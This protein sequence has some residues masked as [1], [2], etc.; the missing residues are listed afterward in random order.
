MSIAPALEKQIMAHLALMTGC[1]MTF[2]GCGFISTVSTPI[3]IHS[4]GQTLLIRWSPIKPRL[5]SC[6]G[7]DPFL[8]TCRFN[9]RILSPSGLMPSQVSAGSVVSIASRDSQERQARPSKLRRPA[10]NGRPS[11]I[12][13]FKMPSILLARGTPTRAGIRRDTLSTVE[14]SSSSDILCRSYP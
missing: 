2:H 7:P 13:Y 14:N 8:P 5:A 4:I 12:S 10:T 3:G 11:S 9:A 1:W 6:R